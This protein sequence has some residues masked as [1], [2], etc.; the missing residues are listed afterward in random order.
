MKK[1]PTGQ[2][3]KSCLERINSILN[4]NHIFL[5][6]FNENNSTTSEKIDQD[7]QKN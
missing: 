7:L 6:Q 3:Y 1:E 2:M 4:K 5:Q